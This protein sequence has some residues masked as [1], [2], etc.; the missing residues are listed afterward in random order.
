MPA[1][2]KTK[3]AYFIMRMEQLTALIHNFNTD[4]HKQYTKV[5]NYLGNRLDDSLKEIERFYYSDFWTSRFR[6]RLR[7][8]GFRYYPLELDCILGAISCLREDTKFKL[9]NEDFNQNGVSNKDTMI[10]LNVN[11]DKDELNDSHI[12]NIIMHE[13]GHRQYN[14]QEFVFIKYLNE[15][16]IGS[17][18]LYLNQS[19][20]EKDFS[21]FTNDNEIRQRIIPIVKEMYDNNW[22]AKEAYELSANLKRDDIKDIFTK[23]YIIDL[24]N[25]IL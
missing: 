14:Q 21:Y 9:F 22:T 6:R 20:E 5:S 12:N 8:E 13:F 19:L 18:S 3:S 4:C 24:L 17:P 11:L 25:N 15:L 7:E 23:D 10:A 2:Y 1:Q 16:T